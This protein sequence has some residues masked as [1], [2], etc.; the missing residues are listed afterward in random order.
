M[1]RVAAYEERLARSLYEQ[2]AAL[3]GVRTLGPPPDAPL[4]GWGRAAVVARG[5]LLPR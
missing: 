5:W 1:E 4:V 3:P 2:L